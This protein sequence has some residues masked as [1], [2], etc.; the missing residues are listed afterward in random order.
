MLMDAFQ[1]TIRLENTSVMNATYTTPD[2]VDTYVKSATQRAS[3]RSAVKLRWTRSGAR[4]A[5]GSALVVHRFLALVAPARPMTRIS[6]ATRS[7]PTTTPWRPRA[8]HTLRAP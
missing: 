1:P 2:H 3:G 6:R 7:R 5:A 4:T 8:V